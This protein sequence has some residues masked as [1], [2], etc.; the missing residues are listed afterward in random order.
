MHKHF[1]VKTGYGPG[2]AIAVLMVGLAAIGILFGVLG[3]ALYLTEKPATRQ[4][5]MSVPARAFVPDEN[6]RTR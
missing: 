5:L 6:V 2:T 4:S 1:I 3:G